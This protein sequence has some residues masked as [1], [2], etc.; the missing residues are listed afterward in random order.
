MQRLQYVLQKDRG[1]KTVPDDIMPLDSL[2][3]K[4]LLL[5]SMHLG[6]FEYSKIS[7]IEPKNRLLDSK[8][9]NDIQNLFAFF[10]YF[11]NTIA[12]VYKTGFT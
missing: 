1:F 11:L 4:F 12:I 9:N 6:L 10:E 7:N 2:A 3:F 8:L 5:A